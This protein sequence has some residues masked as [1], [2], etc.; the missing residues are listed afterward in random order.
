MKRIPSLDGLRAFSISLVLLHHLKGTTGYPT[1]RV[2][3]ELS[4]FGHFGVTVFFVISGYLITYLLLK[5]HEETGEVSISIAGA[6]FA[7][8]QPLISISSALLCFLVP[9][10][11]KK[12]VLSLFFS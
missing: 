11:V 5:E 8:F 10:R 12:G 4:R 2:T 9:F 6:L 3:L 7:F 1:N